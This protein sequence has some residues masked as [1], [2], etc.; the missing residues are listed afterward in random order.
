MGRVDF[1][2]KKY[3]NLLLSASLAR[4]FDAV[5][6]PLAILIK[7]NINKIKIYEPIIPVKT[8]ENEKGI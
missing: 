8:D 4:K 2:G 6:V 1:L 3:I 7:M 5:I